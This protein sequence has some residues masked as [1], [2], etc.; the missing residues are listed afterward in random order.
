MFKEEKANNTITTEEVFSKIYNMN[1]WGG[2]KGQFHSGEGSA[3]E[4][5]T[6]P[7]ISMIS[8]MASKEGFLGL[9]FVD[10]GCG[11]FRIGRKLLPMCS[12]YVGIDIV[13][14][15]IE[16]NNK[17]FSNE[18]TSFLHL[19]IIEDSLPE[20]DVCF[21][22]QVFQHLSNQQ[23]CSVLP[24]LSQY[25]WV[26]ITEHY[27]SSNNIR[28]NLDKTHGAR[29]RAHKNSGVYLTEPPFNIPHEQI[30]QVLEVPDIYHGV[31]RTFLFKPNI[32]TY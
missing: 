3:N 11:D 27:P 25:K 31:I 26:F 10:L 5:I 21:V 32:V 14:P 23:I 15:L 18:K 6:S 16:R 22:R 13:K 7:Y 9:E 29:I 30:K 28:P 20:A 17:E 1:I 12:H 19:N 2:E 24:K 8:D 4:Q